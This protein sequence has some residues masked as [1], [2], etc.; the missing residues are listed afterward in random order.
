[1]L[2]VA[3]Y[4]AECRSPV[5][6]ILCFEMRRVDEQL[7]RQLQL[8]RPLP[9]RLTVS[10]LCSDKRFPP[11]SRCSLRLRLSVALSFCSLTSSQCADTGEAFRR[12]EMCQ[13]SPCLSDHFYLIRCF[14]AT[15]KHFF[16]LPPCLFH[17]RFFRAF[18]GERGRRRLYQH[19]Q[20]L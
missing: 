13:S 12:A 9:L 4:A 2:V 18:A 19:L 16:P 14:N 10:G 8:R 7:H 6:I 1:M 17:S 11:S 20:P 5:L 3:A 15:V